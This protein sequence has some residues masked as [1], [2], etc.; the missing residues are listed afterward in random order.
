[1]Y[2]LLFDNRAFGHPCSF[3]QKYLRDSGCSYFYDEAGG[4][5]AFMPNQP[6]LAL[7]RS[8]AVHI[9]P[10]HAWPWQRFDLLR[11]DD[12]V[13]GFA[14]SPDG[15]TIVSWT[16]GALHVWDVDTR[17]LRHQVPAST[18]FD[19]RGAFSPDGRYLVIN[20]LGG[21]AMWDT[22]S[23]LPVEGLE[24]AQVAAFSPDG[25]TIA[26]AGY[27]GLIQLLQITNG[28]EVG[29]LALPGGQQ[30]ESLVF[31]P[32]G[33]FLLATVISD[34]RSISF[35]LWHVPSGQRQEIAPPNAGSCRCLPSFSPDGRLLAIGFEAL[36]P[37]VFDFP[38]YIQ[39]WQ[40]TGLEV[41]LEKRIS[42]GAVGEPSTLAFSSDG[43]L[44]AAGLDNLSGEVVVFALDE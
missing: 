3:V 7:G 32:D 16:D 41:E 37:T 39:L 20:G 6:A 42:L 21:A 4:T 10:F 29:L 27:A 36:E 44:L 34:S 35:V 11:H 17:R 43:R 5:V 1:M 14:L 19:T 28:A 15:E 33:Q 30:V 22:V 38:S 2:L 18:W 12:L 9:L 8:R 40:L 24:L 25:Q 26:T 31:S 23:W 13:Y